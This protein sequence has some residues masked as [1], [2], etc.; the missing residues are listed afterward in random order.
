MFHVSTARLHFG[1]CSAVPGS[2]KQFKHDEK[3]GLVTPP[4]H[5]KKDLPKGTLASISRQAGWR[6]R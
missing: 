6:S 3:P 2:H 4:V 1:D 5:G